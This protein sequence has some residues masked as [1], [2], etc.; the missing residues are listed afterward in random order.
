M[1]SSPRRWAFPTEGRRY[2]RLPPVG[3]F[4]PLGGFLALVWATI[5]LK[6]GEVPSFTLGAGFVPQLLLQQANVCARM[7]GGEV[8]EIAHEAAESTTVPTVFL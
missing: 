1:S 3:S 5:W 4:H 6:I 8:S 7:L 2:T